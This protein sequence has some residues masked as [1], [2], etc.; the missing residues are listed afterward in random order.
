MPIIEQRD[1]V[2]GYVTKSNYIAITQE[3]HEFGKQVAIYIHPSDIDALCEALKELKADAIFERE[4][5]ARLDHEAMMQEVENGNEV[6]N[7]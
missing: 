3:S 1:A 6:G 7:G 4:N 5:Q 2:D